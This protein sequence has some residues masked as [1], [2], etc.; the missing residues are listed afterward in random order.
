MK[1]LAEYEDKIHSCSK[2][3]LCQS[4]CPIYK[5]TGNDCTVSRGQFIMLRGLIKGDLKMS[6]KINRYLDLCLK[7]GACSKFCPSDID[8]VDIIV[9]AKAEYFKKHPI[10]KFIS[11]IQRV[12]VFGLGM[13]LLGLFSRNI[14]GKDFEKKVVYFG[15]CG[16]KLKG[17]QAVIKLLNSCSVQVITPDFECC[18][19]PFLMRGDVDNFNKYKESFLKILNEQGINEVVTSCAS[20]EKTLKDYIKH[21]PSLEATKV[22]NI[23][24]Y[25]RENNLKLKL[26]KNQRVTFHKP[27]NINNF[28]DIEWIL[29]NT[30]N[31]DYVKMEG[32]DECC[33]LNGVSKLN[34]YRIMSKVFSAKHNNIINTG[35]QIVLTSCLGCE[36]ALNLFSF[37]KYRVYDFA[38][39]LAS[40][41][42]EE[43]FQTR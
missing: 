29:N 39:F 36:A 40:N 20:C 18:G 13:K 5:V 15:G 30:E 24:E 26:K 27:C 9:S 12:F 17:N 28:E 31:L 8:V 14:K 7:C 16:N 2:C 11:F 43:S 3:G 4:V 42:D 41:L 34:E 35:A 38:E 19:I 25:I 37:G 21:S 33:G 22:K 10:E 32:F 6:S 1:K 23:Y